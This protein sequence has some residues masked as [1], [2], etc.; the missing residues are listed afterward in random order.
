MLPTYYAIIEVATGD[1]IIEGIVGHSE[2]TIY[3]R[4]EVDIEVFP[5]ECKIHQFKANGYFIESC[6]FTISRDDVVR[7]RTTG[8]K[9]KLYGQMGTKN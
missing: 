8:D 7:N 3:P 1:I 5:W 6:R 4:Q 9:I 2:D